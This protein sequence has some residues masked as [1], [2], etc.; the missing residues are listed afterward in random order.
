MVPQELDV[1]FAQ[2]IAAIRAFESDE[3]TGLSATFSDV[4]LAVVGA[5]RAATV[6]GSYRTA[7]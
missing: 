4:E 2:R 3:A 1:F 6:H 7:R 5:K